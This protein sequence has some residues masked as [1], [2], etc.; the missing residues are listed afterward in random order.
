MMFRSELHV[1]MQTGMW[2]TCIKPAGGLWTKV[3]GLELQVFAQPTFAPPIG[4]AG[5]ATPITFYGSV[6]GDFV[7]LQ[8]LNCSNAHIARTGSQA[9]AKSV[10]T[11]HVV[12]TA[13]NMTQTAQLRVCYA[14]K[15][16]RGDSSDDFVA[17]A[18]N[19][20]QHNFTQAGVPDWVPKR[21][22][23]GAAQQLHVVGAKPGDR[24]AWTQGSC[25]DVVQGI[26]STQTRMYSVTSLSQ[27]FVL[28]TTASAGSWKFCHQPTSQGLWTRDRKSVV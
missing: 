28:H 27:V 13:I 15:Q 2:R 25:R 9:L 21:T 18:A 7:V 24:V 17:L 14:T 12:T 3:T 10:V 8:P 6:D 26:S 16:S 4:V 20:T 22:S 1:M 19:F 5:M 23:Q 11:N